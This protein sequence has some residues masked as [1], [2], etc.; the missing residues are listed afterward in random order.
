MTLLSD[1][2][3]PVPFQNGVDRAAI[4]LNIF[5]QSGVLGSNPVT[6]AEALS[7]GAIGEVPHFNPL[8][9]S[10]EPNYST[11]VAGN[12]STPKKITSGLQKYRKAYMNDSWTTMDLTRE[13]ASKDPLAAITGKIGQFWATQIQKRVIRTSLGILADNVANDGGDMLF[14][15]ATDDA[16]AVTDAEKISAEAVLSAKST[17]GDHA[18]MLAVIGMHSVVYTN[19]QRQQLIIYIPNA[20][21]EVNIPTYLGYRV[22]VDDGMPAVAGANRITY[23]TILYAIGAV[24]Y[25]EGA[26]AVPSEMGREADAGDGGGQDL[27]YSRKTVLIHPAGFTTA[28]D[29]AATQTFTL[30]ELQAAATWDR[31]VERKNVAIAFLQTNG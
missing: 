27:I 25:G 14:S 1:V 20:R 11:D 31:A 12:K 10:A 4:E 16:A 15:I 19:L 21:G 24:S 17:L 2:Y 28:A 5:I 13:L 23:T 8:D 26:P 29:P 30:A 18:E 9:V 22:V 7:S 6:D 3:V